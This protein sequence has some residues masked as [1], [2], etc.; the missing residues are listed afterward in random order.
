MGSG[1][2]FYKTNTRVVM[3]CPGGDNTMTYALSALENDC[4]VT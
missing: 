4:S 3:A 2:Q 1:S